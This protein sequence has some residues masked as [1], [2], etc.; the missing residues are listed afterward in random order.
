MQLWKL[1]AQPL[2]RNPPGATQCSST[3]LGAAAE[4][5]V[6]SGD[7]GLP[8]SVLQAAWGGNAT[9][10]GAVAKGDV[11][12]GDGL[13]NAAT[14]HMGTAGYQPGVQE[15][16]ARTLEQMVSQMDLLTQHL[17]SMESRVQK[18]EEALME[19]VLK[20]ERGGLRLEQKGCM[21]RSVMRA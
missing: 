2:A 16:V 5:P 14:G 9:V 11:S 19:L 6:M 15:T 7:L 3:P 17:Q 12:T 21:R 4:Q 1:P 13:A 8:A 18:N 20:Q 10:A